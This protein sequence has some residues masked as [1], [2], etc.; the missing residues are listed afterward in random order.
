MTLSSKEQKNKDFISYAMDNDKDAWKTADRLLNKFKG[1]YHDSYGAKPRFVVN[2]FFSLVNL[3][4]PNFI[5]QKP[6][7]FIKPKTAA[8][9]RLKSKG[10]IIQEDNIKAANAMMAV[11]NNHY[12]KNKIILEDRKCIQ[13]ALFYPFGVA[14][15]GYDETLGEYRVR[16][17]PRDFGYHPLA[18]S[19]DDSDRLVHRVTF[20]KGK[21]KG[22]DLEA[23]RDVDS[24]IPDHIKKKFEKTGKKF[25]ECFRDHVCVYEVH[26]QDGGMIYYYAGDEYKLVY[27][28]E[29][30]TSFNGSSFDVIK[31]AGDI[32]EFDGIPMMAMVEDEAQAINEIVTMMYEHLKKFP[33]QLVLETGTVDED[34]IEKIRTGKQGSILVLSDISKFEKTQPLPMGIDYERVVGL[35]KN[36]IDTTLGV[37]DFQRLAGSS[38]KSAT[39]ASFIQGDATVRRNYFLSLVKDFV[40]SGVEKQS[41]MKQENMTRKEVIQATGELNYQ[42]FEISKDDIKGEH[43]FDFDVENMS[44][45]NEAH[46]TTIINMLQ[47]LASNP[48]L[49]PVISTIDPVKTAKELFSKA[50]LKYEF[51]TRTGV[52]E[53]VFI[54]PERENELF[55]EGTPVEPKKSED[56]KTHLKVHEEEMMKMAKMNGQRVRNDLNVKLLAD[57]IIK[58]QQLAQQEMLQGSVPPPNPAQQQGP[59]GPQQEGL[60]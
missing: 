52:E 2:T 43:Q 34:E 60:V 9:L 56:H 46:M 26:D 12:D 36:M 44:A 19:P 4:L 49:N 50:G 8:Y 14:K 42:A 35:M 7:I 31:F 20:N 58:T 48:A 40:L 30:K 1:F 51:F 41:S 37:P 17:N 10:E 13:D 39:E 27:K 3:V 22:T 24:S 55:K 23:A 33:G 16:I 54:S 45:A 38:R 28:K 15:N 5:F 29:L 57:H 21:L 59:V 11:I 32:D 53:L 47:V 18:T 25:D 6:W